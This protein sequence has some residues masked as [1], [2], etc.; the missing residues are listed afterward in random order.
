MSAVPI[1]EVSAILIL[2]DVMPPREHGGQHGVRVCTQGVYGCLKYDS[3]DTQPHNFG[4][5]AELRMIHQ[6]M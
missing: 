2:D 6:V 5:A 1:D 4:E 3:A